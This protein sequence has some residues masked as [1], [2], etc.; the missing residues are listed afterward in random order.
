[1]EDGVKELKNLV[2]ELKANAVKKDTCLD[3]LQ[4]RS[5]E[6]CTLLGETK[7]A[8]IGNSRRLV[9]SPTFWTETTLLV[10]RTFTWTTLNIS[11]G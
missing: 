8:T 11:L 5:D 6:L 1:M 3:Y 7:E 10:S 4:K 2:E 9:S